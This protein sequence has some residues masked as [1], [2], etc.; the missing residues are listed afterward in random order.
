MFSQ[1]QIKNCSQTKFCKRSNH[2]VKIFITDSVSSSSACNRC[3]YSTD[4]VFYRHIAAITTL[5]PVECFLWSMGVHELDIYIILLLINFVHQT[6]IPQWIVLARDVRR[7]CNVTNINS[8]W[9]F[10]VMDVHKQVI[11][12]AQFVSNLWCWLGNEMMTASYTGHRITIFETLL[13]LLS[14]LDHVFFSS[15]ISSWLTSSTAWQSRIWLLSGL[16]KLRFAAWHF[17]APPIP[18]HGDFL[19]LVAKKIHSTSME[20]SSLWEHKLRKFL[21][22]L[23][24]PPQPSEM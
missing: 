15:S 8:S 12:T 16:C 18:S 24:C 11:L 9:N 7:W 20:K 10:E 3:L 2:F 22:F 19:W 5:W 21:K 4:N 17:T 1:H 6:D 13:H 14:H 23:H